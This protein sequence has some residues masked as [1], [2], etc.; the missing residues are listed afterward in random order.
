MEEVVLFKPAQIGETSRSKHRAWPGNHAADFKGRDCLQT[1]NSCRL[2]HTIQ[3][4]VKV[5]C[6]KRRTVRCHNV[7]PNEQKPVNDSQNYSVKSKNRTVTNSN[8][9]CAP[10]STYFNLNWAFPVIWALRQ[11]TERWSRKT[12]I[13]NVPGLNSFFFRSV[14]I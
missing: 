10:F 9:A 4:H 12:L 1:C 5:W 2:S 6:G 8:S 14:F 11:V 7:C 13:N 3:C